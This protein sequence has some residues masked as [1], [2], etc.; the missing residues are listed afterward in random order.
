MQPGYPA[1][2]LLAF[3]LIHDRIVGG[4]AA[5]RIFFHLDTYKSYSGIRRGRELSF[6]FRRNS[7]P[8]ALGENHFL[9]VD[10]GFA[11]AGNNAV[12][13]FIALVRMDERN[14]CARRESVDAYLRTGQSK[15]FMK[16]YSA[17]ISD[18]CFN[19]VFHGIVPP[20]F[21]A[22]PLCLTSV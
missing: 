8:I 20:C 1:A 10:N 5:E 13:L 11:L 4:K 22:N 18:V 21:L 12:Y 16:L 7:Q 3:Y 9:A 19:V 15:L 6:G 2:A 17:P 14:V